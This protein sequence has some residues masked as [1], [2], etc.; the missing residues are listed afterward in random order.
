MALAK[1]NLDALKRPSVFAWKWVLLFQLTTLK[2]LSMVHSTPAPANM[3]M[4]RSCFHIQLSPALS[5]DAA[6]V[7]VQPLDILESVLSSTR[8]LKSLNFSHLVGCFAE[9]GQQ[10]A[11]RLKRILHSHAHTLQYLNIRASNSRNDDDEYPDHYSNVKGSLGCL[12]HFTKLNR[13]ECPAL[14]APVFVGSNLDNDNGTRLWQ[15]R[16]Y[17]PHFQELAEDA[18]DGHFP[19]LTSVE[20]CLDKDQSGDGDPPGFSGGAFDGSRTSFE[21]VRPPSDWD[22]Q[23]EFNQ[24]R[25]LAEQG[26]ENEPLAD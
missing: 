8:C 22:G 1:N 5:R 10:D 19:Q 15:G 2:A 25:F 12:Q 7:P 13:L 6:P 18:A 3:L 14:A 23:Q 16:H 9:P 17:V 11:A 21:I 4:L 20:M 24:M 26:Y